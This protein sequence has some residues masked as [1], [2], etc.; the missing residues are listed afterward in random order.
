[1]D[2]NRDPN[3]KALKKEEAYS[4]EV[5]ISGRIAPGRRKDPC[6]HE[7]DRGDPCFLKAPPSCSLL[8]QARHLALDHLCQEWKTNPSRSE[9]RSARECWGIGRWSHVCKGLPKYIPH[10]ERIR[11]KTQV[12]K[13]TSKE[14]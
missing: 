2:Y 14:A 6:T 7:G 12:T 8:V 5:Y 4:S 3:I 9:H 11:F 10:P 1:M 13:D